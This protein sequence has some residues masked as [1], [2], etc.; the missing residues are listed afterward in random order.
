MVPAQDDAI[1][2]SAIYHALKG[3]SNCKWLADM[4]SVTGFVSF[5]FFSS[6]S[7]TAPINQT[8]VKF[9]ERRVGSGML[10]IS[11]EWS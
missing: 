11:T 8:V 3:I 7:F 4:T 5:L 6:D 10:F 1:L 9:E 2:D